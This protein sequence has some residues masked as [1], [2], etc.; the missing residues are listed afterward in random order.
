MGVLDSI[1]GFM[2][3]RELEEYYMEGWSAAKERAAEAE[4]RAAYEAGKNAHAMGLTYGEGW[5]EF[6]RSRG[7]GGGI[8]EVV[9][10]EGDPEEEALQEKL[11]LGADADAEHEKY[12]ETYSGGATGEQAEAAN[13]EMNFAA[14]DEEG[15]VPDYDGGDDDDDD[16]DEDEDVL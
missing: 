11:A 5:D 12:M 9:D 8:V 15:N 3:S 13:D 4:H 7:L 2:K 1:G 16:D 6:R 14:A 10:D